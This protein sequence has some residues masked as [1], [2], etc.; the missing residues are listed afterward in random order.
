MP[1]I[2]LPAEPASVSRLWDW[3]EVELAHLDLDATRRDAIRLCAEE[4]ATNIVTHAYPDGPAGAQFTV[5]LDAGPP[6]A[7]TF[8]DAGI[9][10][11]PTAHQAVPAAGR[12]EDLDIGGVGIRLV[13]GFAQGM[14]YGR[15]GGTNRLRL[16]FS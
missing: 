1:A 5:G 14:A 3:L 9:A 11:D 12:A 16:T 10:F 15:A 2:V 6:V 13:R 7:L 8:E 4:I